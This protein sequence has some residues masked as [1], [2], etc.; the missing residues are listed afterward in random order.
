MLKNIPVLKVTKTV[1]RNKVS[2]VLGTSYFYC[3]RNV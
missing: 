3:M 1:N 2:T